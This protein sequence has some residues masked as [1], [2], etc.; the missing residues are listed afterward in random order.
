MVTLTDLSV[1]VT[2]VTVCVRYHIF[3]AGHLSSTLC[4]SSMCLC[5]V[6]TQPRVFRCIAQLKCYGKY[7]NSTELSDVVQQ[8][9]GPWCNANTT[10]IVIFG[11]QVF[12]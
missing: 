10:I 2:P 1:C 5:S 12:S 11:V 7:Q 4:R 3:Q 6:C 9:R 8:R